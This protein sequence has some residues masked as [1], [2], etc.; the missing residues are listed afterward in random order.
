M[1]T[2]RKMIGEVNFNI[3]KALAALDAGQP[4]RALAHEEAAYDWA[5]RWFDACP[6]GRD[7]ADLRK[8]VKAAVAAA[9]KEDEKQ[10]AAAVAVCAG[11]WE[12]DDDG[13]Q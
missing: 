5:L 4:F 9:L 6:I 1:M 3:D 10:Q 11:E 8:E 12:G 13:R 2:L 7:L